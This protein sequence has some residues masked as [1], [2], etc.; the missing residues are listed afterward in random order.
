MKALHS[1]KRLMRD[2][3][4]EVAAEVL[5]EEKVAHKHLFELEMSHNEEVLAKMIL[6][7]R[8][9]DLLEKMPRDV[10]EPLLKKWEKEDLP[11]AP[12]AGMYSKI[13]NKWEVSQT[14][15]KK[16][17]VEADKEAGVVV[18]EAVVENIRQ[19]EEAARDKKDQ[20]V[21]KRAVEFAAMCSKKKKP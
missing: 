6:A 18:R 9:S 21:A 3:N 14:P 7:G 12:L 16:A 2:C 10:V 11:F 1:I 20:G 19:R 13:Y 8:I 17:E 15:E 4:C 5:A